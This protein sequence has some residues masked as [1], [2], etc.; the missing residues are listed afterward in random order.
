MPEESHNPVARLLTEQARERQLAAV[1]AHV[2]ENI[3]LVVTRDADG[4][5]IYAS[6]SV[7]QMF[8]YQRRNEL[9]GQ[10]IEVLLPEPLRANH[11]LLRKE[12]YKNPRKGVMGGRRDLNGQKRSGE[13]FPVLIEA[14]S[15]REQ[16]EDITYVNIIDMTVKGLLTSCPVKH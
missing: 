4:S 8:G 12:F 15:L 14:H 6:Q 3:G 10:Q 11:I 1:R 16:D 5:I 9:V 2:W 13:T 7:E